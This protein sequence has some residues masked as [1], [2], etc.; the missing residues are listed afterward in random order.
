MNWLI[1]TILTVLFWGFWAFLIKLASEQL[2]WLQVFI[3]INTVYLAVTLALYLWFK[4]QL[5]I[6][7]SP[8]I[9]IVTAG[10]LG[11]IGTILFY[12]ALQVGKASLIVPVTALYPVVTVA[13][14][15][16]ILHETVTFKQILGIILAMLA[17]LLISS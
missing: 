13:L 15:L 14:S 1:L 5:T 6:P 8:L 4:P 2:G 9:C 10:L 11:S 16:L 3:I 17:I 7:L 12:T